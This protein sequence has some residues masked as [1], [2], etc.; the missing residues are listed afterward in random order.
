MLSESVETMERG[1]E[2]LVCNK[3]AKYRLRVRRSAKEMSADVELIDHEISNK[4]NKGKIQDQINPNTQVDTVRKMIQPNGPLSACPLEHGVV[5]SKWGAV[6]A[7]PVI[8]GIAAGTEPQEIVTDNKY[9]LDNLFGATLAGEV[10][11]AGYLSGA[12][13][14]VLQVGA[15]GDW[16]STQVPHGYYLSK[17]DDFYLTDAEIRGSIDGLILGTKVKQYSSSSRNIKLS[18]YLDMYYSERGLFNENIKACKRRELYLEYAPT[19]KL[20]KEALAFADILHK[21]TTVLLTLNDDAV[22]SYTND[23]VDKL[24]NYISKFFIN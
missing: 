5:Y 24:S 21:I 15:E 14:Q 23:A 11:E 7:G 10:A 12:N 6:S 16:T 13:G 1:D 9:K 19:E 3:G 4:K 17:S 2:S 20:K 22:E 8:A 18:Q